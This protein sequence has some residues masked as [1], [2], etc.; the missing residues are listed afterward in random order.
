MKKLLSLI[1]A[2]ALL[3]LESVG[4]SAVNQDVEINAEN[5]NGVLTKTYTIPEMEGKYKTQGRYEIVNN[6]LMLDYSVSGIEFNALCS[7]DVSITFNATDLVSGNEGGCYFTVLVDGVQKARDFCHIT[8]INST[9]VTIA[10]DLE[11]GEHTF[12]IYRQTEIERATIGIESVTLRG[13]LMEAPQNK[14]LYI[15]F[16]GAST[17]CGYGN[18]GN[19]TIPSNI[20]PLPLY[21]DATQA[22]P[23][24]TAQ[25]MNADF[26]VVARQGI[27]ASWGWQPVSMITVYPLLRH[28]KDNKTPYDFARQPDVVVIGVGTNDI[29]RAE[30]YGKTDQ[31]ITQSF[32]N[33]LK[34]VREKN[35]N[36]K[37][38]WTYNMMTSK[39]NKFVIE[40]VANVGG[41]EK[42]YYCVKVTSDTTG[43]KGHPSVAGHKIMA[44]ELSDF[45][46]TEVLTSFTPG[47]INGDDVVDMKD[48]TLLSK[49]AAGWQEECVEAAL[50]TNG[51]GVANLS[52]SVHLARYLAGWEGIELS[53]KEYK[54]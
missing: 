48:V 38:V 30:Y 40:A 10:E 8:A 43:G 22:F 37:V 53:K 42:G 27:G 7:G 19:S 28:Q 6:I 41:A 5:L 29:S 46:S 54:N 21:Q 35:P 3:I 17:F 20:A 31:D 26:S 16:V 4:V 25:A 45:I 13:T 14:D 15:E 11:H 52:D 44:K 1:L 23:F 49:L 36:A 34:L 47:D 2:L 32:E 33:M 51:D 12:A 9:T 18:L 24:L 50:D 39:A